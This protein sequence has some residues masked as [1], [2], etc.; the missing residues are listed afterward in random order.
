MRRGIELSDDEILGEPDD[1]V[2]IYGHLHA[3]AERPLAPACAPAVGDIAAPSVQ[4]L[5]RAVLVEQADGDAQRG[6]TPI[7][8]ELLGC[9]HQQCRGALPLG[10]PGHRDLVNQRDAAAAE[11][12]VIGLPY[13]RNVTDDIGTGRD[14]QARAVRFRVIGQV[15]PRLGLAVTDP[16]DEEP[17]DRLGIT[18]IDELDGNAG[19]AIARTMA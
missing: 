19:N 12:G 16:L 17:D 13:D 3:F 18:L 15:P 2:V 7:A 5:S 6:D 8:D 11:S 4:R 1:Q 9:V 14:D 10:R